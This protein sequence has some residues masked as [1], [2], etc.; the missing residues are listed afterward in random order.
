MYRRQF[1][2]T[3]MEIFRVELDM[4]TIVMLKQ[5]YPVI[6]Q[7]TMTGYETTSNIV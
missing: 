7:T 3:F 6:M 2:D 4:I 1:K 5:W